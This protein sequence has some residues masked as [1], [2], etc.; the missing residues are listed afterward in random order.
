MSIRIKIHFQGYFHAKKPPESTVGGIIK[1]FY[2]TVN[3][4]KIIERGKQIRTNQKAKNI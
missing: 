4:K 1:R 2:S 3:L